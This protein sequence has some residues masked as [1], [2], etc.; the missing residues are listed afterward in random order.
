MLDSVPQALLFRVGA[1]Y[2]TPK[3]H[4]TSMPRF[5]VLLPAFLLLAGGATAQTSV[6]ESP[7]VPLLRVAAQASAEEASLLEAPVYY[8]VR[9]RA[10]VYRR[11]DDE[12]AYLEL[13]LREPVI[14]LNAS[15]SR[16][17][18]RTQDGV[19]GYVD[20]GSVSNV[21][22][23]VSKR[24]KAVYLYKGTELLM[25][26]PADFGYNPY[27]DKERR[28]SNFNPDDWRTPEGTFFVVKKNP[29]S[30][31]YKAFVLNYPNT[32][33]AERGLRQGLISQAQYNAIVAAEQT[34][35]MPP[36]TTPLGGMIEI[37]G[38]GTGASSN[39]TQGCVAVHNDQMDE[40]W[41]WVEVGTPVLIE[42]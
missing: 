7:S 33:D 19:S 29:H 26:V 23:R 16:Y 34:F 9:N 18:I 17:H 14:L 30:K 8:V 24:K 22:I 13:G 12:Q 38:D 2:S 21:W 5:F 27:A 32:E 37:H 11:A 4:R 35:S 31:F 40:L 10:Y 6:Q 1:L 3:P 28:G 20:A 42:R 15:G 41:G 36:M 25:K 39:W